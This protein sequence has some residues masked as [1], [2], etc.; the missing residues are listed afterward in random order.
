MVDQIAFYKS[1]RELIQFG[2][3]VRLRSPFEGDGN[4]TAWMSVA[5]DRRRAIVGFYRIL[6]RPVP[7]SGPAPAARARPRPAYRVSLWPPT[8]DAIERSNAI[9][10]G[11]D[12][13]MAAGLL[14]AARARRRGRPGATS[15]P[16]CSSSRRSSLGPDQPAVVPPSVRPGPASSSASSP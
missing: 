14:L 10:R 11:G 8:G 7:R 4:E 2:R 3:F 15:G 13:L 16:G 6:N 5:P 12:D 9:V 1:Q